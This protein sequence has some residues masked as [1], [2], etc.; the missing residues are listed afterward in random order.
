MKLMINLCFFIFFINC[1]ENKNLKMES[2]LT[3]KDSIIRKIDTIKGYILEYDFNVK[4][5]KKDGAFLS[6]YFEKKI[7]STLA[8]RAN[9]TNGILSDYCFFYGDNNKIITK[10]ENIT[11]D[12]KEIKFYAKIMVYNENQILKVEGFVSANDEIDFTPIYNEDSYSLDK[13]RLNE[14]KY[15]D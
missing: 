7:K 3:N 15:Y 10:Y 11:F 5:N 12:K 9:Y 8:C 1:M 14:W 2:K 6:Y 4:T 13:I